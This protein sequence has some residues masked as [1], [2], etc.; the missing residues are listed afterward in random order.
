MPNE[1]KDEEPTQYTEKGH[2]IPVPTR[3]DVLRDLAKVAQPEKRLRGRR[4]GGG[5]KKR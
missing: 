1:P 3:G 2:E 5:K 4:N